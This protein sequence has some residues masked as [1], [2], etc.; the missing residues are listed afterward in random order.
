MFIGRH[1]S[2]YVKSLVDSDWQEGV[3][4]PVEVG[5]E[6]T[7]AAISTLCPTIQRCWSQR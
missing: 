5:D 1:D 3:G 4:E 2:V 7:S 6:L